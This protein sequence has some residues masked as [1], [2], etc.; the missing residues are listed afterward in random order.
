M[1]E[2]KPEQ[3]CP[4]LVSLS[5]GSEQPQTPFPDGK[6]LLRE[7]IQNQAAPLLGTLRLYVLR[8]GLA[9]GEQAQVVALELLQE[10]V[11]E[12][13][14]HADRYRVDS[15]PMAWLLGIAINLMKRR[16]VTSARQA[17]REI[18]LGKLT[19]QMPQAISEADLLDHL[20]AFPQAGPEQ[21]IEADEQA[22]DLLGLVSTEDQRVLHLALLVG[23]DSE[24]LAKR[25]GTN[26][27]TARMRQHRALK[28]LRAAWYARQHNLQGDAKDE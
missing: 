3:A 11:V 16:K 18:L 20:I 5:S 19:Q 12:A 7:Y 6:Q 15:Q 27:G 17:Q 21:E 22:R 14:D 23:C 24:A 1:F 9:Y 13:L 25:L 4:G 10:T 26:P 2:R 28:R 8:S